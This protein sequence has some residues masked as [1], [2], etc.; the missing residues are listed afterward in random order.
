M[1]FSL[2]HFFRL[3]I[4]PSDFR[5]TKA[6][7][8]AKS[9]VE[10][11]KHIQELDDENKILKKDLA[12]AVKG[13]EATMKAMQESA[14]VEMQRLKDEIAQLKDQNQAAKEQNARSL[15]MFKSVQK[16]RD[17]LAETCMQAETSIFGNLSLSWSFSV[18]WI[19]I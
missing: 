14:D 3:L 12:E 15:E 4:T 13:H 2:N 10:Q 17:V 7:S 1:L 8:K 6:I 11:S 5:L 16:E 19:T 9:I 18:S